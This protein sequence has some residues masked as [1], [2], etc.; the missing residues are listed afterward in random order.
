MI[1]GILIFLQFVLQFFIAYFLVIFLEILSGVIHVVLQ[2]HS[3]IPFHQ[4]VENHLFF[5][6]SDFVVVL[7]RLLENVDN[8]FF[9]I[10]ELQTHS[11]VRV[12]NEGQKY[13][14]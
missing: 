8:D 12:Y 14:K 13:P 6:N 3:L 7:V 11:Q 9:L 1:Q 10:D 4:L 5:V 2:F